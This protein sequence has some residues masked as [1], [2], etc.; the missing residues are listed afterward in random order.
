V[1][2]IVVLLIAFWAGLSIS[3][4]TT[5]SEPV[6]MLAPSPEPRPSGELD[7]VKY[8]VVVGSYGTE[9][10]ANQVAR[11]VRRTYMSAH[12]RKPDT[13]AGETLFRVLIGAYDERSRA[14]QVQSELLSEGRRGVTV[15]V[16]QD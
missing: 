4:R 8:M 9:E 3:R 5:A 11:E 14:E 2:G 6:T 12:V 16:A 13:A 15:Q 7:R 1:G 10:K